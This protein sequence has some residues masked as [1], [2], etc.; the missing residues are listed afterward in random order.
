MYGYK[1]INGEAVK[2]DSDK[3]SALFQAYLSG[4][5][6]NASAE[7]AGIEKHHREIT[8]ILSDRHYLGDDFYPAVIDQKTFDQ[9][10]VE[11]QKRKKHYQRHPKQLRIPMHFTASQPVDHYD[12]PVKEAEYL[13]SLIKEAQ[14]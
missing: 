8:N 7:K 1:I 10:Q 6:L 14:S 3:V 5:S 4:L 2:Q 9:V 11:M 12:D 13:Y